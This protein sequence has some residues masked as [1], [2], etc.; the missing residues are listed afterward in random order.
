MRPMTIQ[1]QGAVEQ[2]GAELEN[3]ILDGELAPG[4]ALRES[5]LAP[6]LGLSRNTLREAIRGLVPGGLVQHLPHRGFV[7][8]ELSAE[9]VRDLYR[10]REA[11]ELA[12]ARAPL[13]A[14]RA[15]VAALEEATEKIVSAH[16]RS[17]WGQV[18]RAH[19][20]FHATLVGALGSPRLERFLAH[21]F[22]ELRLVM[23]R[24]RIHQSPE[25]SGEDHRRLIDL[26]RAGDRPGLIREVRRHAQV[27]ERRV[28]E[29]LAE[30]ASEASEPQVPH[31]SLS[32]ASRENS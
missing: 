27:G 23:A 10:A 9:D 20:H 26:V 18:F 29:R 19:R 3:R 11:L 15:R 13:T 17:D 28:L 5:R 30:V 21:L 4:T 24:V 1:R 32:E 22:G 8:T 12:A 14:L 6:Q 2:V 25:Q 16:E 7:V 31:R